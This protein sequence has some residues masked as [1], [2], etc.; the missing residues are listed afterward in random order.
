[1]RDWL[2]RK[3]SRICARSGCPC[4]P[5]P[6][7]NLC[8]RCAED[9]NERQRRSKRGRLWAAERQLQLGWRTA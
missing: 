6:D 3:L 9:H 7:H 2:T 4:Q 8:L 5:L 1:M